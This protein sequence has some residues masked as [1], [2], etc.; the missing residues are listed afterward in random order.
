MLRGYNRRLD[1]L[2]AAVLRVKLRHMDAWNAARRRH[3]QLY[4]QLLKDSP[5]RLSLTADYAEPVY[6]LYI[7]RFEDR[8][9]LQAHL[10]DQG[11]ATGIHYPIPI[12]LQPAYRD[13]GYSKED[14][15]ITERCAE[16]I[17]SL[18]MYPELTPELI[19]YIT[20]AVLNFALANQAESLVPSPVGVGR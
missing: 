20:D 6:H 10:R 2:Q 9:G 12:H 14:F 13:L 5:V 3:A 4:H 18:P 15:P 1:T 7:V 16:Q 8:D 19:E 11:I 17:L